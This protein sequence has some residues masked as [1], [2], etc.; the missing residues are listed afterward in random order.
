MAHASSSQLDADEPG[1]EF[2]EYLEAHLARRDW[3]VYDF[4]DR[5][6]LKPSV[7]FRWKKGYRPDI[8]N[9]RLVA[10]AFHVPLLEVLV[11]A[12]RITA[13]EADADIQYQPELSAIPTTTLMNEVNRRIR[14]AADAIDAA[15]EA[16]DLEG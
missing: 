10:N 1:A 3:S 4:C 11:K 12:G 16:S 14:I 8:G 7:V 15:I 5:S 2:V 6:G 13:L 9:S